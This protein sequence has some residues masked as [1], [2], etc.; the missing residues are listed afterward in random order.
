M[1]TLII[2]VGKDYAVG[3]GSGF[4]VAVFI[5]SIDCCLA[6]MSYDS[7]YNDNYLT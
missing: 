1:I 2:G 6:V 5:I 3:I 7:G 4:P